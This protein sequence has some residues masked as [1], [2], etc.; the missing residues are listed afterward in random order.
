MIDMIDVRVIISLIVMCNG[1]VFI[2]YGERRSVWL[3]SALP[4]MKHDTTV[5]NRDAYTQ[6]CSLHRQD[7]RL[8]MPSV[9]TH[10][11]HPNSEGG[12]ANLLAATEA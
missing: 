8:P 2:K 12:L 5:T 4:L 1:I 6:R 11:F 10:I 3:P 9:L 7:R